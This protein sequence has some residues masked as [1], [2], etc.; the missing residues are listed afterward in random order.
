MYI[1]SIEDSCFFLSLR[2]HLVRASYAGNAGHVHPNTARCRDPQ[3]S[4]ILESRLEFFPVPSSQPKPPQTGYRTIF[5]ISSYRAG[6]T[7]ML[8]ESI[9]RDGVLRETTEMRTNSYYRHRLSDP[10]ARARNT[11]RQ[12]YQIHLNQIKLARGLL[13]PSALPSQIG[14]LLSH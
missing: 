5:T 8:P 11:I 13:S 4:F 7:A 14:D 1:H 3:K 12:S 10:H 6:A 9:T 2:V